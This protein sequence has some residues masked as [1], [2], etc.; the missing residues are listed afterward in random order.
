MIFTGQ[1]QAMS[2]SKIIE[3][4]A[5][6]L[7]RPDGSFMLGSR[8]EGKPYAGYWEFPGGKVEPGESGEQALARE[9]Y[10]EM[11]IEMEAATPWLTKVHHY[12]HASVRLRFFRVWSWRG[13]PQSREGQRFAWQTPGA[14]TVQPML[15]ANGPILKSLELPAA[16]AISCAHEIGVDAQLRRLEQGPAWSMVQIREPG[17]P[18]AELA[19]FVAKAAAIVHGRGGKLLVNADPA[20]AA[21]WPVDGVH[22]N[23]A[24]LASLTERPAFAWVGASAHD[25]AQVARIGELGLDYALLGHVAATSSHPGAAP[26]GWDGFLQCLAAGAPAPVYALGGMSLDDLDAARRHGAHGVAL[27]RGAWR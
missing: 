13:E 18:R 25:A 1:D 5:G 11:G 9:L 17:M 12:E 21:E 16:Y 7:M 14:C 2:D 23:A 24:R 3:V 15:P 19:D 8:P 20:W 22:L 27:M 26:L 6:A 10:E 4:V